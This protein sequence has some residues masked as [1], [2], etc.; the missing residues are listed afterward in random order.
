[1]L[2]LLG[3]NHGVMPTYF[4]PRFHWGKDLPD[5]KNKLRKS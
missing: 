2:S 5:R 3:K 1:M 4:V